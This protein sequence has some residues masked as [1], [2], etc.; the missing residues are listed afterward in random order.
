MDNPAPGRPPLQARSRRTLARILDA[1][2]G[3]I[4]E[5]GRSGLTVQDVVARARV[6]VGSFYARFSGREELLRFL[7]EDRSTLERRRWE[8]DLSSRFPADA[9]LE[10][11]VRTIV[12]LLITSATDVSAETHSQLRA[13]AASALLPARGIRHSDPGAA[14][15]LAYAATL[16]AARN[17]PSG[18][19][20]D[21]LT[22]ELVRMWL[23]YL[24]DG[25]TPRDA[26]K[27]GVDFFDVWA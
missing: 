2:H 7:D 17:P 24:G 22:G 4:A 16:G 27:G 3:L 10:T 19:P 8:A 12:E 13:L 26:P 14:V 6:S 20:A 25:A 5:R 18:W 21:R 9:S 11:R 1:A 15:D 23:A